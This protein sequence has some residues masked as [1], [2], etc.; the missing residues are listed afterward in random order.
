MIALKIIA[1]IVVAGFI[2]YDLYLLIMLTKY[3]NKHN[4]IL[5]ELLKLKENKLEKD[6]K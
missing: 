4:A 2:G 5:K 1:L 3:T 6:R